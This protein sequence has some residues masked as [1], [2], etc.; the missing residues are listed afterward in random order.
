MKKIYINPAMQV[1]VMTSR[2]AMM[3]GSTPVDANSNNKLTGFEGWGGVS[4]ETDE[5]D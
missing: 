4:E 5:A 3:A 2:Q 1:V